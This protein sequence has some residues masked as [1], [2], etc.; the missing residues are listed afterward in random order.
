MNI[1]QQEIK[2]EVLPIYQDLFFNHVKASQKDIEIN[3]ER[4]NNFFTGKDRQ[5]IY[6]VLSI[7]E[8]L[9]KN[10]DHTYQDFI[11]NGFNS[12]YDFAKKSIKGKSN[13]ATNK[14]IITK[15]LMQKHKQQ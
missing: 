8:A 4:T 15:Y 14:R 7:I 9:V 13:E 3:F 6:S 10:D 11:L 1:Q 12:F 2:K 5:I